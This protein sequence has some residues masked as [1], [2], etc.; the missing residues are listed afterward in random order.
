MKSLCQRSYR[1]IIHLIEQYIS[2][3]LGAKETH[4]TAYEEVNGSGCATMSCAVGIA[5]EVF[6]SPKLKQIPR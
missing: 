6:S 2:D 4:S 3:L 1:I 5:V